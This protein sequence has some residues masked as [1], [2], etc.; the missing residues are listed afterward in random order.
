VTSIDYTHRS[1][2]TLAE[3]VRMRQ[4]NPLTSGPAETNL[5]NAG[6][7]AQ[8]A[9]ERA[10]RRLNANQRLTVTGLAED[11][12]EAFTTYWIGC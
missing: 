12:R 4:R 6:A 7:A 10:S 1:S 2:A 9:Y 3:Q 8:A 5:R 11:E